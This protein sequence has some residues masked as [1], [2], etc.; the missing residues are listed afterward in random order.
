M[1]NGILYKHMVP[2]CFVFMQATHFK[3][4]F[5]LYVMCPLI[6]ATIVA[7]ESLNLF[8][9]VTM[10]SRDQYEII[11]ICK[12]SHSIKQPCSSVCLKKALEIHQKCKMQYLG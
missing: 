1:S 7:Q 2:Y 10:N 6:K 11:G 12:T 4:Q 3:L 8:I 5:L 9:V